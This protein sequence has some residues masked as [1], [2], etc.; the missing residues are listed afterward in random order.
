MHG[1]VLHTLFLSLLHFCPTLS[2]EKGM[3][4]YIFTMIK[5]LDHCFLSN[6][7]IYAQVLKKNINKLLQ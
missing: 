7:L 5:L 6:F 4:L 1:V 3:F 2:G